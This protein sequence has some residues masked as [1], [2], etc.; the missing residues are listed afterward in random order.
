MDLKNRLGLLHK[1]AEQNLSKPT[2]PPSENMKWVMNKDKSSWIQVPKDQMTTSES[3]Q[4]EVQAKIDDV[5][6]TLADGEELETQDFGNN[7]DGF[8]SDGLVEEVK[9]PQ[10]LNARLANKF[11]KGLKFYA[12]T[13]KLFD[14]VMNR[15][16]SLENEFSYE[17]SGIK[18][19][20]KDL[21]K[22]VRKAALDNINLNRKNIV[23]HARTNAVLGEMVRSNKNGVSVKDKQ[24]KISQYWLQEIK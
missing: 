23:I 8:L 15:I 5:L 3:E 10:T 1:Q 19:E 18:I 20:L 6:F 11:N 2:T 12:A 13:E 14:V 22:T 4:V 16:S 7:L 9:E 17:D 24:G 21:G